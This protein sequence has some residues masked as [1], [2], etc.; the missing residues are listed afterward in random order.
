MTMTAGER[1]IAVN[2]W[3]YRRD[4]GRWIGDD[5]AP[6]NLGLIGEWP[7][8]AREA[9]RLFRVETLGESVPREI[10]A[11]AFMMRFTG[12]ERAAIRA[13]TAVDSDLADLYDRQKAAHTINLDDAEVIAGLALLHGAGIL[14]A[15]RA[16]VIL[17]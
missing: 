7:G 11:Y 1:D 16:A 8:A 6:L 2:A 10:T 5:A 9:F 14:A 13:A 12:P 3:L 15:G 17:A 4:G